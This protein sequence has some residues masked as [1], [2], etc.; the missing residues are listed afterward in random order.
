MEKFL[1]WAC[2]NLI[3][4]LTNMIEN[5]NCATTL[6][7][8]FLGRILTIYVI[9]VM[10]G[11]VYLVNLSKLDLINKNKSLNIRIIQ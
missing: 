7:E 10:H 1:V 2:A 8:N 3:L 5:Q 9:Y 6:V 11:K 4:L